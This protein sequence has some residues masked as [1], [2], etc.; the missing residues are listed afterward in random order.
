MDSIDIASICGGGGDNV[1]EENDNN[2][3]IVVSCITFKI[4]IQGIFVL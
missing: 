2:N 1:E 4:W 3:A